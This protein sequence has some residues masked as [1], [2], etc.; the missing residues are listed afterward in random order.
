M[1]FDNIVDYKSFTHLFWRT[2]DFPDNYRTEENE[3]VSK[4]MTKIQDFLS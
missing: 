3:T 2:C 1:E 4:A